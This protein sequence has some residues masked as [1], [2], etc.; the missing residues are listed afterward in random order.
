MTDTEETMTMVERV[1]AA[2]FRDLRPD[3]EV[4]RS[5][6][7]DIVGDEITYIDF[8]PVNVRDLARAAIAAMAEPSDLV[9]E[10][11]NRFINWEPGYRIGPQNLMNHIVSA[12]LTE[13]PE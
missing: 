8:G 4:R 5:A 1:M 2:L 12:A 9:S 7:G 10:T 3:D 11:I 13:K 6:V